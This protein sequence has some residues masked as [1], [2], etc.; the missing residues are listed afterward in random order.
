CQNATDGSDKPAVE[1]YFVDFYTDG[2]HGGALTAKVDG[3]EIHSGDR[4][5]QGKIV[6][7]TAQPESGKRADTWFIEGGNFEAGSG[8]AGSDTAKVRILNNISVRVSFKDVEAGKHIVR[9]GI[10]GS[11]GESRLSAAVAGGTAILSGNEVSDGSVVEFTARPESGK[12]VDRWFIEGGNFEAGSGTAGSDTARVKV[13]GNINVRVAFKDADPNKHIVTFGMEGNAGESAVTAKV[14]EGWRIASGNELSDGA[15]VEFTAVPAPGYKVKSWTIVKTEDN[16]PLLFEEGGTGGSLRAKA[17]AACNLTVKVEFE[18]IIYTIMF[19]FEGSSDQGTFTAQKDGANFVSG[20]TAFYGEEL[21]F[22][23]QPK[24][25]WKIT[26]W[27]IVKTDD[28]S[29][30]TFEKGGTEGSLTAKAKVTCNLTVKVKFEKVICTVA[31]TVPGGHGALKAKPEGAPVV[32]VSPIQVE[33]GKTVEFTADPD[34]GY[35]VKAWTIVNTDSGSPLEFES[36][37]GTPGS[38]SAKAKVFSPVTVRVEFEKTYT[39]VFTVPGGHGSLTAKIEDTDF[40]TG[41]PMNVGHGKT[42]EFTA[43]PNAGYK[44]KEWTVNGAVVTADFTYRLTVVQ[45]VHLIVTFTEDNVRITI[46]GDERVDEGGYID[47]TRGKRWGDVKTDIG[48]KIVLKEKWQG[49]NYGAYQWKLNGRDG[50]TIDDNYIFTA[51]TIVYIV[52]NYIKFKM[53]GTVLSGYNGEKPEGLIIIGDTVTQ[54]GSNAFSSCIGLTGVD[55]SACTNLTQIGSSAF[56]GCKGLTG[57][58]RLPV[59]LTEIGSGAF[60]DCKG[61]VGELKLPAGL[62][63]ISYRAFYACGLSGINFSACTNLRRIGSEA[64]SS[65]TRLSGMLDLPPNLIEIGG[66]AFYWCIGLKS[67]KLPA[68]LKIIGGA[69][70][71]YCTNIG[72]VNLSD[73]KVL[74]KIGAYAFAGCE[75][76]RTLNLPASITEIGS[77]AFSGC[78]DIS[79]ELKLPSGLTEICSYTFFD[80][81]GLTKVDFSDCTKLTKIEERAFKNC[82]TLES[83]D[84]CSCTALT[85]IEMEVFKNCKHAVV[86]LPESITQLEINAF[87]DSNETYCAKVKIKGGSEYSRIYDL[88]VRKSHYFGLIEQY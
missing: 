24:A 75:N 64:F 13:S 3:K 57:R 17:R 70:F 22:S 23:A 73:C 32:S 58:L 66:S 38:V 2:W 37:T 26:T 61:I 47:I 39:V 54:I 30:L 27:T 21:T 46:S 69:G 34:A 41:S 33:Y 86:R 29:P 60:K 44:V 71:Q 65:C 48:K 76:L 87:G 5:E 51:D 52:T 42:V 43:V 11:A 79:G 80:C 74:T 67:V 53:Q 16:N 82:F 63:E 50:N 4:V 1:R 88:V 36:G 45:D 6:E 81:M 85:Q 12:T 31:F 62:T 49:G 55:F 78:L 14:T 28:N 9:F 7:F 40:I 59:S 56:E 25:G 8:T 18:R 84:L 19:G 77:S 20:A 15:F 35:K 68:N 10:E 83:V 72:E